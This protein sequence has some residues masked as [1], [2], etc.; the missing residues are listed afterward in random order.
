M[1]NQMSIIYRIINLK[2]QFNAQKC[3]ILFEYAQLGA[4]LN[5]NKLYSIPT[6]PEIL[7]EI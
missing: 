1:P 5:H 2:N 6:I 7:N 4:C 3:A